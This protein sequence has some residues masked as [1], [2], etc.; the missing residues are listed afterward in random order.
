MIDAL[1]AP[2]SV[3]VLGAGSDIAAA[4]LA[5]WAAGGRLL[6]VVLA[7]RPG[8]RRDAAADAARRLAPAASVEVVDFEATRTG[9]HAA[10]L[11][12]VFDAGDVDV[13]LFAVGTLP[14][15]PSLPDPEAAAEV[16]TTN[17]TAGVTA[18]TVAATRM[19]AAGHG[20]IVVL[21]SVAGERVRA[22]NYL[23]GST[24]AGL[25]GFAL[26]L[27]EELRGS[28]VEVLVVRPGFVRTRMTAGLAPAPLAVDA[29]AVAE[30]VTTRLAGLG[31]IV[32]V[33]SPLRVVMSVLRH[34]PRPLFRRLPL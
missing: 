31:G 4:T 23:Y 17:F 26:G 30:A 25:D 21:S 32:W 9:D 5:R 16:V 10:A 13:V 14:D 11:H 1:G 33:P 12:P 15:R 22:S 29:D 8:A 2:Q 19:R 7:G 27:G 24:K 3:L 20:R 34:V 6:R 18:L 28:G